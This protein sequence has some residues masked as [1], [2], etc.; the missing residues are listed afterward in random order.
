VL[1]NCNLAAKLDPVIQPGF[2]DGGSR[3]KDIVASLLSAVPLMPIGTNRVDAALAVSNSDVEF[4]PNTISGLGR[5]SGIRTAPLVLGTPVAKLGRTTALTRGHVSMVEFDGVKV[6]YPGLGILEFSGQ[7][8]VTGSHGR[9]SNG[10]DSGSLIVDNELKAVA[11]LF[12]GNANATY[13]N[14]LVP[15]LDLLHAELIT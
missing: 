12:A 13:C 15:V 9:F 11:L 5:L 10:G 8:E 1:A 6:E 14:P 3:G 2:Q 4:E 7:V